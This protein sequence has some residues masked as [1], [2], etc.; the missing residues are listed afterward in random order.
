MIHFLSL[1]QTFFGLSLEYKNYFLNELYVCTKHIGF[2]RADVMSMPIWERRNYIQQLLNEVDEEKK[3][4]DKA[5]ST[6]SSGGGKR[7][8]RVST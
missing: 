8:R 5:N 3:Q 1:D 7:T 6:S 4:I 2:S